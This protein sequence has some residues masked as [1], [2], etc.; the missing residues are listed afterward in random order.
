MFVTAQS[1][2]TSA[3]YVRFGR[4]AEPSLPYKSQDART[5]PGLGGRA[6]SCPHAELPWDALVAVLRTVTHS[7]VHSQTEWTASPVSFRL[8]GGFSSPN[9]EIHALFRQL[10][11]PHPSISSSAPWLT[12][13]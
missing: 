2:A 13:L 6:G 7:L 9:S 4:W 5:V 1:A 10:G 12:L 3:E 8:D 11:Y